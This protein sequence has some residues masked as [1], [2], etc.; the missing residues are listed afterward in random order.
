MPDALT[1]L[2]TRRTIPAV[3][4][5]EPGP[6]ADQIRTLVQIAVRVPDHGKLKP[7]RFIAFAGE[8][9]A[10]VGEALLALQLEE[11]PDLDEG[12]RDKERT[13]FSRAP[14]VI[15]VVSRTQEHFKV[16]EWEQVMSAGAACMNLVLGAHAMG[17]AAQWL[18][19]WYA[20]DD[21]AKALFGLEKGE[22]IVGFV[23]IGTPKEEPVD[24]PRPDVETVLTWWSPEGAGGN[25]P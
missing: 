6:D 7:W 14:L 4:L 23:H 24:R 1:L 22:N 5:G 13:R 9:R 11:K 12:Q 3:A 21:K 2:T 18:T 8:A 20:F 15:A 17:F 16:P 10:Q 25:A 19:E